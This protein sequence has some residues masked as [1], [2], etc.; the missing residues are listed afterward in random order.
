M[1]RSKQLGYLTQT[2]QTMHSQQLNH[3][4]RQER[5]FILSLKQQGCALSVSKQHL[6]DKLRQSVEM[7]SFLRNIIKAHQ[8]GAFG[9]REGLGDFMKERVKVFGIVKKQK[10]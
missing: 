4:H 8:K 7:K 6:K 10:Q 9:G 1:G 2:K 3:L 5:I